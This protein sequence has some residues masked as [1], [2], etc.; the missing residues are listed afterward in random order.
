MQLTR[1]IFRLTFRLFVSAAL[2]ARLHADDAPKERSF[3]APHQMKISVKMIGPVTQ[4][5]DLQIIC[6]FKHKPGGD[7]YIEAMQDFNNR[8]GGLIA[9]VRDRG[10]FAGELGETFLF[11]PP[12]DS[13]APKKVLLIGLGDEPAL[14]LDTLNVI[15]RVALREAVRLKAAHVGFAPT[16]RDQGNK[17]IEVGDCDRAVAENVISA[18][19]TEKRLQQQGLAEEFTIEDWTIEAGPAFFASA[20]T[21]VGQGIQT[22]GAALDARLATPYVQPRK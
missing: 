16:I 21:K 17:V 13:I 15:G 10:E 11:I 6:V 19:D 3:Q 12:P 5:A 4:P 8:L 1:P 22:A 7:T 2:T 18:Y 20:A 14:S 9:S